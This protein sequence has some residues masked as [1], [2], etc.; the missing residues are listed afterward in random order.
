MR[1]IMIECCSFELGARR[2]GGTKERKGRL[3]KEGVFAV[4]TVAEGYWGYRG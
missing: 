1:V 3:S 4:L 2:R